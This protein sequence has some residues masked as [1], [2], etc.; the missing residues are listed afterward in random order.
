MGWFGPG[1]AEVWQQLARETRGEFT[2]GGLWKEDRVQVRLDPWI[3]TLDSYAIHSGHAHV[4]YTRIRA[5]YLNPDGF[6]FKVYRKSIFSELGKLLGMQHVEVDDVDI[7]ERFI[8][9]GND[10][11][12]V[13][14][15][16]AD[17]TICDLVRTHL[18][19]RLEV[20]DNEGWF[21]ARYPVE[22]DLLYFR[23]QGIIRDL[24]QLR[25]LIHLFGA[26]LVRLEQIG[27]TV[28]DDPGVLL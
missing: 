1:K 13:R 6:R 9:Q 25:G 27:A 3:I 24:V 20:K 17:P 7:S 26:V 23:C 28:R 19:G 12:K 18:K 22:T 15:L 4:V 2:S 14:D 10:E 5:P 21:Q 11:W 8:I 16:F